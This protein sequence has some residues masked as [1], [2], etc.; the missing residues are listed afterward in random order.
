MKQEISNK[1]YELIGQL[2]VEFNKMEYFT[3]YLFDSFNISK[4]TGFNMI[5]KKGFPTLL[6]KIRS[7]VPQLKLSEINNLEIYSL[8]DKIDN[9][10]EERNAYVHSLLLRTEEHEKE[11][12]ILFFDSIRENKNIEKIINHE[13]IEAVIK[14]CKDIG[15]QTIY[16]IMNIKKI[17]SITGV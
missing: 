16:T 15:I 12:A 13:D 9:M 1:T 2:S 14:M 10:R 4:K 17:N 5:S 7:Y 6:K 8:L 11:K 3:A